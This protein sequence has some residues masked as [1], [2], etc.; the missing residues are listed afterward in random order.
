[1]YIARFKEPEIDKKTGEEIWWTATGDQFAVPYVFKTLFSKKPIEPK[2]LCETFAVQQGA[3]YL[4]MNEKLPDVSMYEKELEKLEDKYK[5]GTLS[6]VLFESMANELNEKIQE[7]HEYQF[8]GRTGQFCP[9]K[10]GRG[11]GVLYRVDNDKYYAAA[12]TTGYRWLES[13]MI[14]GSNEDAIDVSYYRKLVDDAIDTISQYG[15]FEWFAS[16]DPYT[17][18]KIKKVEQSTFNLDFMN[19]PEEISDEEVPF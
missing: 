3:L 2:D 6:D 4:D 12:G 10:P 17:P 9:I 19:L 5:K 18:E 13:E 16:D 14:I 15:D 11:G 1:M 8:V 7:G